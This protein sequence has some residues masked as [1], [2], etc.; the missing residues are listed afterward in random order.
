MTTASIGPGLIANILPWLAGA[1]VAYAIVPPFVSARRTS[2]IV[3]GF[4]IGWMMTTLF[5]R[6]VDWVFGSLSI[7]LVSGMLVLSGGIALTHAL[8]STERRQ[9]PVGYRAAD[10]LDISRLVV[11]MVAG[12]TGLMLCFALAEASHEHLFA[13]DAWN[14]WGSKAKAWYY[15]GQIVPFVSPSHWPIAGEGLTYRLQGATAH[16]P[17]VSLV[18]TWNALWIGHWPTGWTTSTW[19]LAGLMLA[20]SVHSF[21]RNAGAPPR[22][23]LTTGLAVLAIPYV[24]IHVALPGYADLWMSLYLTFAFGSLYLA[25]TSGDRTWVLLFLV[26]A[27]FLTQLKISGLPWLAALIGLAFFA[28]W[29]WPTLIAAGAASVILTVIGT[30][31]EPSIPIF[32][33]GFFLADFQWSLPAVAE[34]WF[35]GP[36][37]TVLWYF[38]CLALIT[39]PW[40]ISPGI[41][42]RWLTPAAAGLIIILLFSFSFTSKSAYALDMRTLNRATLHI[43]G[44][45]LIFLGIYAKH[46]IGRGSDASAESQ[47]NPRK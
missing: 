43:I 1:A 8:G 6:L 10:N 44:P 11:L 27:L 21:V 26:Y 9:A 18:M 19:A 38:Y 4:A 41:D 42:R 31:W 40:I 34:S 7:V 46:L 12:V 45:V 15:N 23:A 25:Q 22:L 32:G 29:R 24:G 30:V 28:R 2:V 16:P 5:L 20:L 35:N 36:D 3:H 13:W 17:T 14:H 39:S 37:W 47:L 33:Q